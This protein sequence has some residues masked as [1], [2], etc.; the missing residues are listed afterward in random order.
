[1]LLYLDRWERVFVSSAFW[2]LL[3]VVDLDWWERVLVSSANWMND[4]WLWVI[5]SVSFPFWNFWVVA[6]WM[7]SRVVIDEGFVLVGVLSVL[8]VG[9]AVLDLA[10]PLPASEFEA[11]FLKA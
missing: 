2:W 11:S 1:M 3:N 10:D 4:G 6:S 8:L 9:L 5:M 7:S